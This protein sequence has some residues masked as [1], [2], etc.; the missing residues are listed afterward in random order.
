M[1][2]TDYFETKDGSLP[3]IEVT[4]AESSHVCTAFKRLFILG[5][6]TANGPTLRLKASQS[7]VAFR[8]PEDAALVASDEVEAFQILLKGITCAGCRL[9]DLGV[10]VGSNHLIL[11]YRMGPEWGP[12]QIDGLIVLL[13]DL[14]T[15]GGEI[16]VHRYWS[17][18][19]Q[20]ILDDALALA[21]PG[22]LR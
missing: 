4:F 2:L 16:S 18:E 22:Q 6:T 5:A 3:E 9:P 13:R 11:D 17:N 10:F 7:D 12:R 19:G 1:K 14:Q 8:G 20:R 15:L 21:T